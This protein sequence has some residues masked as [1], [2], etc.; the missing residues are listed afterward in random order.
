MQNNIIC[1]LAAREEHNCFNPLNIYNLAA[2]GKTILICNFAAVGAHD[3]LIN[4]N[5]QFGSPED[6]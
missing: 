5:L 4:L 1:N 3:L 6:T 2:L